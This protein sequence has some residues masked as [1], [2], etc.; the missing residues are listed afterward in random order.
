MVNKSLLLHFK[1]QRALLLSAFESLLKIKQN[2]DNKLGHIQVRM[3]HR[4]QKQE[5]NCYNVG[6]YPLGIQVFT[7]YLSF[8]ID[9]SWVLCSNK[10]SSRRPGSTSQML[11]V[12]V[13]MNKSSFFFGLNCLLSKTGCLRLYYAL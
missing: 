3:H 8:S 10:L 9:I 6:G 11:C 1:S 4:Y 12:C 5:G 13:N 2:Q 7:G